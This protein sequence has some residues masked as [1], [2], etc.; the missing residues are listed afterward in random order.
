MIVSDG[1]LN[2]YTNKRISVVSLNIKIS[3]S[4]N[5]TEKL[6]LWLKKELYCTYNRKHLCKKLYH[7]TYSFFSTVYLSVYLDIN[8]ERNYRKCNKAIHTE[9]QAVVKS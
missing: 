6:E 8:L 9:S 2:I 5:D 3:H 4:F 1:N 7:T